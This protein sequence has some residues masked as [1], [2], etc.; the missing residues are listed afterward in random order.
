MRSTPDKEPKGLVGYCPA[1][2]EQGLFRTPYAWIICSADDCTDR[3]ALH[4]I[5]KDGITKDGRRF[6]VIPAPRSRRRSPHVP[7]WKL[8]E[9][10]TRTI[11][12]LQVALAHT[13]NTVPT[14]AAETREELD[15]CRAV[16]ESLAEYA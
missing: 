13:E 8:E 2:G 6:V 14:E 4:D 7:S 15:G 5:L 10:L 16:L 1:C 9:Q 3:G 12:A 11:E